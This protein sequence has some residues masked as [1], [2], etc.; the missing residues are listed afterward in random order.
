MRWSEDDRPNREGGFP[1]MD[2]L[3][4]SSASSASL[5]SCE[6]KLVRCLRSL[7]DET[8]FNPT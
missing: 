2:S 5:S 8:A 3:T 7:R 1:E 6:D 4:C